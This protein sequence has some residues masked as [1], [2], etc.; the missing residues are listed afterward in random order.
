MARLEAFN[1]AKPELLRNW[2]NAPPTIIVHSNK[3]YRCP[4]TEGLAAFNTLQ[5]H[6]VPSRFLTFSDEGHVLEGPENTL[7]WYR[8]VFEWARRCIDGDIT[9]GSKTW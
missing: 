9:R 6:G 7:E 4:I 1:P 8:V 5:A 2:K 3:D